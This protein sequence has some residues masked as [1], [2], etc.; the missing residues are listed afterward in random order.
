MDDSA[1]VK[2][3]L[4]GDYPAFVTLYERHK[5]G[6]YRYIKRQLNEQSKTDDL[7]QEVWAKVVN[8]LETFNHN[9]SFTTW[10]YAIARNSLI[11]EVRHMAVVDKTFDTSSDTSEGETS[12]EHIAPVSNLHSPRK[13]HDTAR[14]KYAIEHCLHQLPLHQ[15][16]CFL[17]KE[18]SGLTA[19]EIATIVDAGIEATKSRLRSAYKN[20]RQCLQVK[21]GL[22]D[23][24]G[25][26]EQG[27]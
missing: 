9:A 14:T 10:L 1:L 17:L 3:Y 15:K 19:P 25:D 24:A 16:D 8:R 7:F 23:D 11:D 5:G 21:L 2:A 22:G 12:N 13:Q 27:A 6:I 4:S 18:E 20:L 26:L